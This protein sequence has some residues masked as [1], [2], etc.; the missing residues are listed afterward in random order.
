MFTMS[1]LTGGAV[2]AA[3]GAGGAPIWQL[4]VLGLVYWGGTGV[5]LGL[6]YA[7]RSGRTQLLARAARAASSVFRLPGWSALPVTFAAVG[8]LIAMWAGVWDIGYH[9]DNGRDTGPLGNPGHLPLLL[10]LFLTFAGGV[11]ALG[12]ADQDDASPAW[13]QIRRGWRVP[14]G[15][16]LLTGCMAFGMAALALDDLWHRVYGQDV[17]LW[18]P[19]HFIYL[20]GGVLTVIGML[21]LLKEGSNARAERRAAAGDG[22][23]EREI[24]LGARVGVLWARVQRAALLGGLLCGLELFLA[25]YDY[26]VPLYRQVWQPLLL[27]AFAGF[28]FTTARTWVGRGGALGAGAVYVVVRLTGIV[29][30]AVAG[31][32]PS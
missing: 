4:A 32:S 26:G 10:G 24:D 16:V 1:E 12:L 31:V 27:A 30:P 25:E 13:V 21:V 28:I 3:A 15:G 18:S 8:L 17:T 29:I 9:V 20:C 2:V 23:A 6:V 22:A 19:T 5:L 11:L 7:H 14:L